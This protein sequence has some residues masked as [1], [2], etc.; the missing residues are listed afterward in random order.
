MM[1]ASMMTGAEISDERDNSMSTLGDADD[2]GGTEQLVAVNFDKAD[3]DAGSAGMRK[4]TSMVSFHSSCLKTSTSR[5]SLA[6]SKEGGMR[7]I[8][9]NV[10]FG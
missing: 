6:G 8:S 2:D 4:S 10:S 1:L 7:R 9:S 3:I 5:S